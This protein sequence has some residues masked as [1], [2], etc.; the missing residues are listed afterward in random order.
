MRGSPSRALREGMIDAPRFW[1]FVDRGGG[2][3]CCWVWIGA[4]AGNGYGLFRL[5]GGDKYGAH[6]AAYA[7]RF[8]EAPS[9]LLICHD[10]DQR[11]CVNPAH[12][13]AGTSADNVADMMVKGRAR[14]RGVPVAAGPPAR[15]LA[16]S[17]AT[18]PSVGRVI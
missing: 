9:G 16:A 13:F 6:R 10:C 7:L 3:D 15:A 5:R 4:Q 18:A 8:G 1:S 11:L 17:V 2:P 12:M 14:F